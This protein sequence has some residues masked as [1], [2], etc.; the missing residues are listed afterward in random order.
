MSELGPFVA[1]AATIVI[2]VFV[3]GAVIVAVRRWR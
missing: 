2:S 3:A 1:G